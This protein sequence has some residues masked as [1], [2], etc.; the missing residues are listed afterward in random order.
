MLLQHLNATSF[1]ERLAPG[2]VIFIEFYQTKNCGN[3]CQYMEPILIEADKMLKK[4]RVD[5]EITQI[6]C[7]TEV[8]LCNSLKIQETLCFR[9]YVSGVAEY[10]VGAVTEENI[11]EFLTEKSKMEHH[12]HVTNVNEIVSV[13]SEE[14]VFLQDSITF[15]SS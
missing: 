10:V 1:Q 11:V 2:K 3:F 14:D 12:H 6:D 7:S 5:A 15:Y 9:Y 13:A 4:K 8:E